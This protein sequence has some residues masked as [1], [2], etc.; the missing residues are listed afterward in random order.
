M[1]ELR[2]FDAWKTRVPPDEP[3]PCPSS[4]CDCPDCKDSR[5]AA[6]EDDAAFEYW[7]A[8]LLGEDY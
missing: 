7:I 6:D 5:A 3:V 4:A 8:R 1:S 2:G